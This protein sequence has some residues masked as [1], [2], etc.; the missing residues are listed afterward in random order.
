MSESK[1]LTIDSMI[2]LCFML[3]KGGDFN[4]KKENTFELQ[5]LMGVLA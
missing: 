1:K 5:A 4:I 2:L 3:L